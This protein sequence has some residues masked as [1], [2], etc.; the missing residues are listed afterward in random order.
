MELA[1]NARERSIII[2][3]SF[4]ITENAEKRE[5]CSYHDGVQSC[6]K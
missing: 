5:S 2:S 1:W 4:R 6:E 3:R